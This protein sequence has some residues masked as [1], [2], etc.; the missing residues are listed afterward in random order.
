[1]A[2]TWIN[3]RWL[4]DARKMC[5]D[6][7]CVRVP[8]PA[9][10]KRA[11]SMHMDDPERAN[12]P[13]EY[14]TA[15]FGRGARWSVYWTAD[16]ERRHRNFHDYHAA[17]EFRASLE[18]DI[19]S[20]RY[21][22]PRDSERPFGEVAE[23]WE[24]TLRG[25]I[26]QSTEGRYRRELRVWVLPRWGTVPL[27]RIGTAMI[28]RWVAQLTAGQA[29]RD[30]STGAARP[31]APKTIRSIVDVVFRSV[32]AFAVSNKWLARNPVDGVKLPKAVP[33]RRRV[34]LTPIEVKCLADE[35]ERDDAS[36]VFL[37]AYTG[38]RLGELLALRCGDVDLDRMTLSVTKT[39]SVDV[40]NRT[41]ET[42][43]KGG[44]PRMVPIPQGLRDRVV[45]LVD[46]HAS[47]DYLIRAPRGG[48]QTTRNWRNRVWYPALRA[49][50][51]DGIDGLTPHS[52]RHTYASL[53]IKAGADVKSLQAVLGHAS[54]VET[55][56]TYAD[57]WPNRT[58]E[59]AAALDGEII[60]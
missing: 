49:A 27:E 50:G 26:K 51:M 21:V 3:D 10:V 11:L 17:E 56:D 18:N 12:V 42:I 14:R 35:M 47:D 60:A 1:M 29:P 8:P 9:R 22:N 39:Q 23:Q 24:A 36:A 2:K 34:Y 41:I 25:S 45:S 53:A 5:E 55:L 7:T 19:R 31:L 52:L 38:L 33:V 30:A 37:L 6:G 16:G 57:L 20:S 44:R 54:A 58:V 32:L 48:M 43:P 4:T 28:Q 15:A 59:V 13:V 46:G 40:G